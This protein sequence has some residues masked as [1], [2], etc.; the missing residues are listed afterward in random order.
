M[1]DRGERPDRAFRTGGN[2]QPRGQVR[3]TLMIPDCGAG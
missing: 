1:S 2:A 3:P